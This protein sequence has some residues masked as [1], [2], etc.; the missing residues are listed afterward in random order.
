MTCTVLGLLK[1]N[2]PSLIVHPYLWSIPQ[3]PRRKPVYSATMPKGRGI[4]SCSYGT[5]Q[6]DESVLHHS[7]TAF[8]LVVV[9]A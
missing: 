7:R 6:G 8:S 5:H 2:R 3:S 4:G 9:A 1:V